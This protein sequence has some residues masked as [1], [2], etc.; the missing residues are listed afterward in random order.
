VSPAK[1]RQNLKNKLI[2]CGDFYFKKSE[3]DIQVKSARHNKKRQ[4]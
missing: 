3:T 2:V 4:Y 1:N